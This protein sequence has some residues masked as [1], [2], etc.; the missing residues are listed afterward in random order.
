MQFYLIYL[1]ADGTIN[2]KCNKCSWNIQTEDCEK[3]S[4]SYKRRI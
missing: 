4:W 2:S 1:K 3:S